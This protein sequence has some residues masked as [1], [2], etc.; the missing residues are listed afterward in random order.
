MELTDFSIGILFT[1]F[2]FVDFKLVYPHS[3][4]LVIIVDLNFLHGNKLF[5]LGEWVFLPYFYTSSYSSCT[6]VLYVRVIL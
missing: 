5:F 1:F 2:T 3:R 6:Y 4:F